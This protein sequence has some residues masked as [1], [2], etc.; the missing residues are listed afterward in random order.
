[1]YM[2]C[3]STLVMRVSGAHSR[4]LTLIQTPAQNQGTGDRDVSIVGSS[5]V[6][7]TEAHRAPKMNIGK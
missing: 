4:R 5:F 6:M 3:V 1:M 7:A 2:A